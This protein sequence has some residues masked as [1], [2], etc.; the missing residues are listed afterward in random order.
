MKF[1]DTREDYF[2]SPALSYSFLKAFDENPAS[3]LRQNDISG[4]AIDY[5]SA[6]DVLMFDGADELN[7]RFT[8]PTNLDIPTG[9]SLK[10]AQ[11]LSEYNLPIQEQDARTVINDLHL[12]GNMKMDT[13]IAKNFNKTVIDYAEFLKNSKGKTIVPDWE[14]VSQSAYALKT[15]KYTKDFF[16]S[17]DPNIEVSY[18]FAFEFDKELNGKKVKMKCM[19]DSVIIDH[20]AKLIT[21]V[22]LKTTSKP[23]SSFKYSA[24][25]YRYDL[26]AEIYRAGINAYTENNEVLKDYAVNQFFFVVS[27]KEDVDNPQVFLMDP[28]TFRYNN[29]FKRDKING[30]NAILE[31]YL[32]HQSKGDFLNPKEMQIKGYICM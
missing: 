25:Q 1:F 17:E 8:G 7:K 3:V 14:K 27:S 13:A 10:L 11:G 4:E 28:D 15:N 24:L 31:N 23:Y 29:R 20:A 26:Q 21:P 30:V 12:W 5:G 32:F 9:M 19:L 2:E 16:N 6:V 22:D 18:Q